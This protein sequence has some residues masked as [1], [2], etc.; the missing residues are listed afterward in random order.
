VSVGTAHADLTVSGRLTAA[1]TGSGWLEVGDDRIAWSELARRA[2]AIGGAL[3]EL[4]AGPGDRVLTILPN[5]LEQLELLFAAACSGTVLVPLSP[6]LRGAF[7]RHQV[8]DADPQIVVA[9][10]DGLSAA[11]PHLDGL[12]GLKAVVAVDGHGP[13]EVRQLHELRDSDPGR[14][15]AHAPRPGDPIAV[16][17][18]SGTTGS[19]KGCVCSNAYYVNTGLAVA[20]AWQLSA[21]DVYFTALPLHHGAGQVSALMSALVAGASFAAPDGFHASSFIPR[22]RAV[23]ATVCSGV[24][25]MARALLATPASPADRDHQLRLVLMS[26]LDV[27]AQE[28]F[29]E[30]FGVPISPQAYG[31]SECICVTV[32]PAAE[33]G[34]PSR[35]VG[36]PSPLFDVA[37]HDGDG[38]AVAA[39]VAGEIVVRPRAPGVMF[40][41]YWRRPE[42]TLDA[43]RGLW[44]HTGDVGSLG[45]DGRLTFLDRAKDAMRR[46]GENVSSAELEAAIREH[47]K[48][49]DVAAH[50]VPASMTEDDIKVCVVLVSGRST[51]PEE[52]FAFFADSLPY[53]AIPRYVEVLPALPRETTSMRV[54]KVQLRERGVTERTWDL[55][56]LGL[57][58][59]PADRRRVQH[60][61]T[62]TI[63]R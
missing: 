46:R 62:T 29:T 36:P 54:R 5:R 21:R 39:G 61:A 35:T 6:F 40:D 41:G 42:D 53:Y 16:L 37:I 25:A 9:D 51:T 18:T 2:R 47:P 28:R 30:R 49:E 50:A 57:T 22:A 56:A 7:L 24:G 13:G 8:R 38:H 26:P 20:E 44:H 63:E 43:F 19:S 10:A 12:D 33:F 14:A 45:E 31:Q 55:E 34:P 58:V 48:I 52:L 15:L 27:A 11:T 3:V 23:G 59:L 32:T 4:G 1:A 60:P 17:Y